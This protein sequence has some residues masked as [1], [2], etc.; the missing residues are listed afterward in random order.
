MCQ[1]Q[2]ERLP[3]QQLNRRRGAVPDVVF[4]VPPEADLRGLGRDPRRGPFLMLKSGLRCWPLHDARPGGDLAG[5]RVL[6]VDAERAETP[7]V[8]EF[9]AESLGLRLGAAV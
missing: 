3:L 6:V 4:V 1:V 7:R 5:C 8:R 2:V 9:V